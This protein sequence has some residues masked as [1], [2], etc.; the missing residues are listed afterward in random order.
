MA[1]STAEETLEARIR[2]ARQLSLDGTRAVYNLTSGIDFS[3][4]RRTAEAIARV[5]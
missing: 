2:A 4:P 5:V 1:G 3:K